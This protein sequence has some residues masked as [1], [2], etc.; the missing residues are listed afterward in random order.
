MNKAVFLD[1]DGIINIDKGYVFSREEFVFQEGIVP[2]LTYF[3]KRGYLLIIV[4]N[5]SGIARGYFT[6]YDLEEIHRYM[7]ISLKEKGIFIQH[8][9]CCTSCDSQNH[10][11]KPNPGMLIKAREQYC[12]AMEKS[13]MIGDKESDILAAKRAGV[14]Y[15]ILYGQG[16]ADCCVNS[17]RHIMEL[18]L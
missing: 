15:K 11:R 18:Q 8:I 13:I 14:G 17:L 16:N 9:Y 7:L 6:L 2:V 4:T 3:Q 1:R 5:Q 10:D 12:I